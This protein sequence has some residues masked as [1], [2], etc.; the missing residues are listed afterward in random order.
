MP[1]PEVSRE[2]ARL[3]DELRRHEYLYYVLDQPV[4]SDAE[5][6]RL[7]RDLQRL[8]AAHP[9]LSTED[10][11][12]QRVGG[13]AREGFLKVTHSSP[14][15]SLDNALNEAELMA[16]DKRIRDLLG[17]EPY[18]YVAELKMDG[19]SM[20]A[21]YREGRFMQAVTRG[22]GVIGEDVTEN[23][24]TI[25]SLPLSVE[26]ELT[27]FEVRGETVMN[28]SAFERLNGTREDQGLNR[29]AN[30]RNAA[31]GSLR[32]LEPSVTASR[33]LDFYPYY[34]LS[35]GKFVFDSQ[36]GALE[37][38]AK[39]HFKVNAHRSLCANVVEVLAFCRGWEDRRE[40]LPYEIDGVVIKIDSVTQQ[41]RLGFT[42]KS[43][44]W[45]IA[46][47]Y[48]A[49][50]AESEVE[51]ISVQVGRT[52]AL[53]P[54]AHLKPV[55]IGGVTV[56]RATL[57]NEDEIER[58]GL[59][60]GEIVAV[61]RSGDVIP[62]VVRVK[63]QGSYRRA[64]RMPAVCPV[65][66]GKVVRE[67]GESASR[68]INTCCPA[69]VKES[70]LHFSSRGVMNIDGLGDAVV[71]QLVESGLVRSVADL[72]ALTVENLLTLERMGP[73]SAANLVRNIANSKKMP[74]PRVISALG[75]RFVGERTS[76]FLSEEFGSLARIMAATDEELQKAGEVGPKIADSI[77]EFFK[78]AHNRDLVEKL[79]AI[80]L[81]LEYDKPKSDGKGS[82]AGLVFVLTGSLEALKR[83]EAASRIQNLGG[84]VTS[85]VSKKTSYVVAGSEPGSKLER[86]RQLKVPVIDELQL[87]QMLEGTEQNK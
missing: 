14:M 52:G 77:L 48:A 3:R 45:A 51:D 34:L 11:P 9:E 42:A 75:I 68:C 31:A 41:Q 10:S 2:L 61:E 62:K 20:A 5:Y 15:L 79:R 1:D 54:V 36:W 56:S 50:Q 38:L 27:D 84:T 44:R 80:G 17:D 63:T 29:F 23:A 76:Q 8:E 26:S 71:D 6:D 19:L 72:Y 35:G 69:R 87:I 70:I 66:G 53:T 33:R 81:K 18:H 64:F 21:L 28:R 4:I 74:L 78:E 16:F 22:D 12:T 32:L 47:K 7:M 85:S 82:L 25:R 55:S 37:W 58:L 13:K 24:R 67:P 59:R 60:I 73:K 86:A 83:E 65:C 43:P 39:H 57:H 40:T 30:P 49:R 46:F